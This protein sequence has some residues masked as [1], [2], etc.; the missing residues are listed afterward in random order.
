MTSGFSFLVLS[1]LLHGVL[2]ARIRHASVLALGAQS[3]APSMRS[4]VSGADLICGGPEI[5]KMLTPGSSIT[6]VQNIRW[7]K[8]DTIA[9][10]YIKSQEAEIEKL[11]GE[12]KSLAA[13]IAEKKAQEQPQQMTTSQVDELIQS[14]LKSFDGLETE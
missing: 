3:K 2:S 11:E 9:N 1:L 14:A 13:R 6:S 12:L 5:W 10:D 4:L 7:H 8:I